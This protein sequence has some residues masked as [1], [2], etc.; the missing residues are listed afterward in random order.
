MRDE[1]AVLSRSTGVAMLEFD[2]STSHNNF[3]GTTPTIENSDTIVHYG[4]T[5]ASVTMRDLRIQV[6]MDPYTGNWSNAEWAR[7]QAWKAIQKNLSPQMWVK[8]AWGLGEI[9]RRRGREEL[10]KEFRQLLG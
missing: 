8:L 2:F 10:Q 7:E 9:G 3:F 6:E 4:P 1:Q 5:Y